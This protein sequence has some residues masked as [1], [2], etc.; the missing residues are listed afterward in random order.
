MDRALL[1][2]HE[3]VLNGILLEKRVIDRKDRTAGIAEDMAHILILQGAHHHFRAGH[4]LTH[5]RLP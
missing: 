4:R 2:P 5:D 3:N 1:V